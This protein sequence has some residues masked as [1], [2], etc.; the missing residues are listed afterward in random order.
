MPC[1]VGREG[2]VGGGRIVQ[3]LRGGSASR[4]DFEAVHEVD[5]R[6]HLVMNVSG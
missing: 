6:F 1:G 2:V 4:L 5:N 3:E